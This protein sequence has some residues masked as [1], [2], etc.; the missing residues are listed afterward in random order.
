[1]K[2]K[3]VRYFNSQGKVIPMHH[4]FKTISLSSVSR[5]SAVVLPVFFLAVLWLFMPYIFELWGNIFSFWM[6]HIYGG[7]VGYITQTVLG[8]DLSLPYPM[9]SAENPTKY[10]VWM[11]LVLC[12][13]VFL[14]SFLL[15]KRAMPITYLFRTLM[16]IQ[17]SASV[18]RLLSPG[19]FPYTL[20]LYVQNMMM[21]CVYTLM[22]LPPLLGL[23]YFIFD[24]PI[25]RKIILTCFM[26]AY[27]IVFLPCQYMLHAFIIHEFT[28]LFMPLMYIFFGMLLDVLGFVC[29]YSFGMSWHS[30]PEALQGRGAN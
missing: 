7:Q 14:V 13:V 8:Q 28:L 17:A 1:M 23:V 24:F 9:L 19:F 22:V 2:Q 20:E 18:Q 16:L 6:D 26:L 15:P 21:T 10:A 25:S 30:K 5:M 12:M 4:A 27:Y 11:N 29:I 3:F